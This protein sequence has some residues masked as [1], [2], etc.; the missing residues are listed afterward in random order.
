VSGDFPE[1]QFAFFEGNL[2]GIV[3]DQVHEHFDQDHAN[4]AV[5]NFSFPYHYN[6]TGLVPV[7]LKVDE[8]FDPER[9][10][11]V[12]TDILGRIRQG[13]LEKVYP[14]EWEPSRHEGVS[15]RIAGCNYLT[16]IM[17]ESAD[18]FVVY[19]RPY[20]K[21]SADIHDNYR[22]FAQEL[23]KLGNT[24]YE[25]AYI[26]ITRNMVEG[27]FPTRSYPSMLLFPKG[28]K[29]EP[30]VL[31][32]ESYDMM[33]WFAARYASQGHNISFKLP[34]E[35]HLA[36]IEARVANLKNFVLPEL[37]PVLDKELEDLKEDIR[38]EKTV[39]EEL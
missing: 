25:L 32:F 29:N 11:P 15:Q 33:C 13:K 28:K 18:V 21:A 37:R 30:K 27:G 9:W 34:D 19:Y 6:V 1:F 35:E 14:S 2:S 26:D 38:K 36:Q 3:G 22:T 8:N 24:T 10:R 39:G 4:F 17:N 16:R 20:N 5:L 23:D 12:I 31:P 7:A